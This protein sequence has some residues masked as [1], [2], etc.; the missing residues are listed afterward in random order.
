LSTIEK[1]I[2]GYDIKDGV[3]APHQT[4]YWDINPDGTTTVF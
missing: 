2:F 4:K 3:I 1:E